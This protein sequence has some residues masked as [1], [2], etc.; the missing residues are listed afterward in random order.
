[1]SAAPRLAAGW[2]AVELGGGGEGAPG[3][4]GRVRAAQASGRVTGRAARATAVLCRLVPGPRRAEPAA[5][6]KVAPS[7]ESWRR[8]RSRGRRV[9]MVLDARPGPGWVLLAG[10]AESS[11]GKPRLR[12]G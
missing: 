6:G 10:W 7:W 11:L 5:A 3:A 1:M 8:R 4:A 12:R 9:G 2:G